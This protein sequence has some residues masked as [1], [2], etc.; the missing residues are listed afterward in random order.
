VVVAEVS[1]AEG[2]ESPPPTTLC[3]P[4]RPIERTRYPWGFVLSREQP[5]GLPADWVDRKLANGFTVYFDPDQPRGFS[6]AGDASVFLLGP[7]MDTADPEANEQSLAEQACLALAEGEEPLWRALDSWNG[8][9]MLFYSKAGGS[10]LVNDAVG[11]RAV[12][13]GRFESGM[14]AS[15]LEL[16]RAWK[17]PPKRKDI[18]EIVRIPEFR[19]GVHHFPGDATPWKGIRFLTPNHVLCLAT[20]DTRRFFPRTPRS[21][22]SL[23]EAAQRSAKLIRAQ[24][25]AFASRYPLLISLS[26]GWDSRT[27]LA[28]A[29]D[30]LQDTKFFTYFKDGSKSLAIDRVLTRIL[31]SR[32]DLDHVELEAMEPSTA[33]H[34]R[35]LRDL[36]ANTFLSHAKHRALQYREQLEAGRVHLGSTSF[37][38]GRAHYRR[39]SRRD[40]VELGFDGVLTGRLAARLY[41]PAL[42]D[43]RV[44]ALFDEFIEEQALDQRSLLGYDPLDFFMWE[45]RGGCWQ[46]CIPLESDIAHPTLSL[47]NHRELIA[48]MLSAP[49]PGRI[50][51]ALPRRIIQLMWPNLL[52]VPINRLPWLTRARGALSRLL[53]G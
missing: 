21:E 39:K 6:E 11:M 51:Q 3:F 53:G 7:A 17:E 43:L 46:S 19:S 30:H 52:S 45:H 25:R 13:V 49:E 2:S 5:E 23:E 24:L 16:L 14:T 9:F 8:R 44:E 1:A 40:L 18:S 42:R 20:G 50:S 12:F 22:I 4:A 29:R 37:V 36:G 48:T 41:K 28:A 15:H 35:L 38:V 33:E 27:T 32:F 47:F 26:G 31:C 34:A 10:F